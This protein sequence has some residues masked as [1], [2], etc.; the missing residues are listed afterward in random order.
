MPHVLYDCS[1]PCV[2]ME[3]K[4]EVCVLLLHNAAI[5]TE[6]G[7]AIWIEEIYTLSENG[8]KINKPGVIEEVRRLGKENKLVC[9]CNCGGFLYLRAG[10]ST[11]VTQHY[12]LK[13]GQGHIQCRAKS[14]NMYTLLS[15][16][17]LKCWIDSVF[18][19]KG[20]GIQYAVPYNSEFS[21]GDRRFELTF[22]VPSQKFGLIHGDVS[23]IDSEKLSFFASQGR[24]K[25]LAVSTPPAQHHVGQ[26]PEYH[27]R[28]QNLQ[29]Y[30]VF[31]NA[32][33]E[34][35]KSTFTIVRYEKNYRG[36]WDSLEVVRGYLPY[37]GITADGELLYQDRLVK[38]MVDE[39]VTSFLAYDKRC[40]EHVKALR[41]KEEMERQQR[42]E[43]E[44]ERK[45]RAAEMEAE[46]K[47]LAEEAAARMREEKERVENQQRKCVENGEKYLADYPVKD[48]VYQL[49]KNSPVF[50][51]P[52]HVLERD[53]IY[54]IQQVAVQPKVVWFDKEE[55]NIVIVN[56]FDRKYAIHLSHHAGELYKPTEQLAGYLLFPFY[57]KK[58]SAYDVVT[59]FSSLY[60]CSMEDFKVV[61]EVSFS[62]GLVDSQGALPCYDYIECVCGK[63]DSS[64]SFRTP[65]KND[66]RGE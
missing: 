9:D 18:S 4:K 46:K 2:I 20:D 43:A 13:P 48:A 53:G 17:T 24:V 60:G 29:G 38:D 19:L 22:Y 15:R 6:D 34:Y 61:Q 30:C 5:C 14:E 44:R 63:P 52:F 65:K 27:M 37:F 56:R 1:S 33:E 3:T 32:Q 49:V 26:Y 59:Y 51:A 47:R 50:Q 16:I 28:M 11:K 21:E 64:C 36:T 10:S 58:N 55:N 12:A 25:I 62:C 35:S 54:R 66:V 8:E 41:E 57:A 45:A 23:L 31:L 40:A 39:K 42:E 7:R